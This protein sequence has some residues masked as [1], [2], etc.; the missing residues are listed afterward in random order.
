MEK[1]T[2]ENDLSVIKGKSDGNV[3]PI[4]INGHWFAKKESKISLFPLKS[5]KNLLS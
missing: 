4:S 5:E 1:L 2:S 3:L